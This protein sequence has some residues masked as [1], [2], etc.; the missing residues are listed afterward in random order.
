[1]REPNNTREID[2]LFRLA[3]RFEWQKWSVLTRVSGAGTGERDNR[4]LEKPYIPV[5]ARYSTRRLV[6]AYISFPF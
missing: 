6:A 5:A 1:M 3:R 2:S 4:L